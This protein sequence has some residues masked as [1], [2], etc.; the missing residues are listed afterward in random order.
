MTLHIF[1][2]IRA[3]QHKHESY[4]ENTRYI[5]MVMKY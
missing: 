1:M 5:S 2:V 3:L 4:V